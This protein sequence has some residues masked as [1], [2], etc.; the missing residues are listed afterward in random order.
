MTPKELEAALDQAKAA[1][2]AHQ[3]MRHPDGACLHD[4][5]HGLSR[6]TDAVR[7][8]ERRLCAARDE[9]HAEIWEGLPTLRWDTLPRIFD[10][11][12]DRLTVLA[13]AT[14]I[15]TD[16]KGKVVGDHWTYGEKSPVVRFDFRDA[17]L[18][19]TKPGSADIEHHRLFG[20]GLDPTRVLRIARS[21]WPGR[22][23]HHLLMFAPASLEIHGSPDPVEVWAMS[24]DDASARCDGRVDPGPS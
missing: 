22:G 24:M 10:R 7:E 1:L 11:G 14:Y 13:I 19:W 4:W 6:L 17:R 21:T 18:R 15:P 20:R 3:A 2:A 5:M 23:R 8:A 9:E 16:W 12:R